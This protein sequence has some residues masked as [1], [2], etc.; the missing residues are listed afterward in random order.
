[1]SQV[2]AKFVT[3]TI[4][5]L[6]II[7]TNML[8]R[9]YLPLHYEL[10]FV[11]T[12]ALRSCHL[13]IVASTASAVYSFFAAAWRGRVSYEPNKTVMV[14]LGTDRLCQSQIATLYPR[15][16]FSAPPKWWMSHY[17]SSLIVVTPPWYLGSRRSTNQGSSS[18]RLRR[19]RCMLADSPC[20]GTS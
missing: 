12:V 19:L 9:T 14:H 6:H 8:T 10:W 11:V 20:V 15:R 7:N 13:H 16:F 18:W 1:M 3:S 17:E 2:K 4:I 5:T